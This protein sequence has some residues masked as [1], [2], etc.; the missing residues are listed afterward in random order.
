MCYLKGL[1]WQTT[2]ALRY[3]TYSQ[4]I[5]QFYLHSPQSSASGMNHTCL[6]LPSQSWSS[7][8]GPGGMESWVGLD[9]WLHTHINGRYQEMNLDMVTHPST[10][11][12]WRR[13]TSLIKTNMLPLC[14]TTTERWD[15]FLLH[16]MECRRSLI[17]RIRSVHPSVCM[18]NVCIVTKQENLSRFLHHAKDHLAEFPEKK[19]GW[20]WAKILGQLAPVGAK[21]PI[22]NR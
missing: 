17:M 12:A 9:C 11:R 19:N 6:F 2:N 4:E 14:Q 5:S 8:I 3:G 18:S 15:Q 21:S 16:C 1:S 7:Y 10:N 20:W 13:L 22:F